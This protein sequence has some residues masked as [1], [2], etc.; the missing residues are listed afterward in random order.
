MLKR[1]WLGVLLLAS[2]VGPAFAVSGPKAELWPRWT[3]HDAT[4][5]RTVDHSA[6]DAFLAKYRVARP[7]GLALVA[8]GKVTPADRKALD[9]YIRLLES[10]NVDGLNRAEQF[11][12]W[13]NLYN[14]KTVQ[15][16]LINYPVKSIRGIKPHPFAFGPWG[17]KIISVANEDLSL[18]D[19]EHRIIRP[20]WP[21][22]RIHFAVNCASIGCPNISPRAF[23]PSRMEAMLLEAT[24]DFIG[25]PRGFSLKGGKLRASSIFEWYGGDFGGEAG[26]L[27][28][29]A[30]YRPEL[31][32]FNKIAGTDYDWDL[33]DAR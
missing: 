20:I 17:M 1:L 25:H 7:D 31:A 8:Y 15:L 16:V 11:A 30:K 22:P 10:T 6:W 32:R 21:D 5:T 13:L 24:R 2:L 27:K 14:A 4:S 3:K 18:D 19:I 23:T 26:V 12:F 29:A 33:N 9:A 28:F